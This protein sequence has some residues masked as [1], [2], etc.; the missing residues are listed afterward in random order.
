MTFFDNHKLLQWDRPV[1][2]TVKGGSRTYVAALGRRLG[3]SVRKGAGAR[4]VRREGGGVVVHD[5]R[6]DSLR[7]DAA[8][9]ATHAPT[10]LALL[11]DA[12]AQERA[13]LGAFRVSSN[14]VV[15]HRDAT[16]MPRRRAAWA[17][18]NALRKDKASRPAVTYWM[19]RLQSIP[20]E[21]P[22]FVTLN[23]D[24]PIAPEKVFAAFEAAHP[25]YDAAA[26]EAQG[27]LA[28]I[29]SGR[30]RF[31]GAWTGYGFHEDGLRSGLAAARAFGGEAPWR[32]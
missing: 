5:S 22:L 17:S 8:I 15:A 9:F 7:Y 1:W 30:L 19:N 32:R 27:R 4:A 23:P 10:T 16:L 6:G 28:G 18:W 3:A 29:Q 13:I 24:R 21:T 31:A 11:A 14:R 12:S 20:D 2:R 26:I 25:L